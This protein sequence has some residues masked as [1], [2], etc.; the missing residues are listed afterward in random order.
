MPIRKALP[1]LVVML[2]VQW[3]VPAMSIIENN[4]VLREG[5]AVRFRTAPID[6][7][8]P[9]R[10]EYVILSFAMEEEGLPQDAATPWKDGEPAHALLELR[11]GEAVF[12]GLQRGV[13]PAGTLHVRCMVDLRE[14]MPDSAQVYVDLPFDR[15][16]VQQGHG[17]RTEEL[18]GWRSDADS[19]PA[20]FAVV[21]LLNGRGVV[22]DLL[23]GERTVRELLRPVAQEAEEPLP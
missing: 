11:D 17:R 20:S 6:P 12:N 9:F 4:R 13:P 19:L 23:V 2:L 22:E 14:W 21:R 18:M 3:L 10:G 7:H 1:L 5:V 8:D 15:Y 16:Y